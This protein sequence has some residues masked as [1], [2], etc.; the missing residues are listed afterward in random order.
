[1]S[2]FIL[3]APLIRRAPEGQVLP[4]IRVVEDGGMEEGVEVLI[5]ATICE[6]SDHVPEAIVSA[7][8]W[9]LLLL[10]SHKRQQQV[11][12]GGPS[13]LTSGSSNRSEEEVRGTGTR[14]LCIRGAELRESCPFYRPLQRD[15]LPA[16]FCV[17]L[18]SV[19]EKV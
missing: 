2:S 1:M 10:Q 4:K 12:G 6:V 8:H 11:R 17:C 9:K 15:L 19:R 13:S 14:G 5:A 3:I 18:R 7:H 16:H